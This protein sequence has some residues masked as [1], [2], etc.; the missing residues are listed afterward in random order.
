MSIFVAFGLVLSSCDKK[1]AYLVNRRT[2]TPEKVEEIKEAQ[3]AK[4]REAKAQLKAKEEAERAKAAADAEQQPLVVLL[5]AGVI[6]HSRVT[7]RKIV[8]L[9]KN[10]KNCTVDILF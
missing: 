6:E 2:A 9:I 4:E 3:R 7:E 10:A 5:S 8:D 1:N